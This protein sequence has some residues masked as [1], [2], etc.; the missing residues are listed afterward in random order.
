MRKRGRRPDLVLCV[1]RIRPTFDPLFL[2]RPSFLS[3]VRA[4]ARARLKMQI[5][6]LYSKAEKR[7]NLANLIEPTKLQKSVGRITGNIT[8]VYSPRP[9]TAHILRY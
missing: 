2:S 7:L 3:S 1:L 4:R 8:S 6:L 9:S 5:L